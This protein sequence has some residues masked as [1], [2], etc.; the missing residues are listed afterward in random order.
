M[1][2][3]ME[4][5]DQAPT[6]SEELPRFKDLCIL[7]PLQK[8][9]TTLIRDESLDVVQLPPLRPEEPVQLLRAA[10]S[11]MTTYAHL[12]NYRFVLE[13]DGVARTGK[14]YQEAPLPC[15]YTG[16]NAVVSVPA[17]MKSLDAACNTKHE[18]VILDEYGDLSPLIKEG[19]KEGSGFRIVLERYDAAAI[20]D[21]ILRLRQLLDGNA[22]VVTSLK[23]EEEIEKEEV[24]KNDKQSVPSFL[25]EDKPLGLEA[26]NLKDFFYLTCGEV[27]PGKVIIPDKTVNSTKQSK[28]AKK[29]N[30]KSKA[31]AKSELDNGTD[32][33]KLDDLAEESF[34]REND[35]S[36]LNELEE[37][38]RIKCSIRYSGFHPPPSQRRLMGDLAYLEVSMPDG[39]VTHVTVIPTGFYVSRTS[40][41]LSKFD[42]SPAPNP[43]FSHELLDCL[44]Q[45][46]DSFRLAWKNALV[47]SKDR[48]VL[49]SSFSQTE[50]HL[51]S[52]HRVAVRGDFGGFQDPSTATSTQ[53]LDQV[54]LRPSWLV[55]LPEPKDDEEGWTHNEFH[56]YNPSRADDDIA[57]TFGLDI[58]SGATRDWNE[59]IQSSREMPAS[60]TLERVEKARLIH[61]VMSE[62]GEAAL[63]GA[64]SIF[65]GQIAPMNPNEPAR[66][67]VYLHNNIFFSRAVDAG[68]ETFKLSKGDMAAKKSASRDAQ[69]MGSLHRLDMDGL[70]T[71]GTVVIDYIGTRFVCQSVVPGILMGEKS[72]KLL[73][74][75]VEATSPLA[76]DK[77]T[78]DILEKYLGKAFMVATRKVPT[79]PFTDERIA[80]IEAIKK[81]NPIPGEPNVTARK[82]VESD[83]PTTTICAPVEAKGI[84]GSDMRTYVLDMPRIT[85]RD[86]NWVP[87]SKGGTGKWEDVIASNGKGRNFVPP[88]LEDEEFIMAVLRSELVTQLTRKKMGE[89]TVKKEEE[90][91]KDNIKVEASGNGSVTE[92]TTEQKCEVNH[93]KI[94]DEKSGEAGES[95]DLNIVDKNCNDGR[96]DPKIVDGLT[97]IEEK[98]LESLRLNVNVFL[99]NMRSLVGVDDEAAK[100]LELDMHQVR[101]ASIYLW[102]IVLP[103]LTVNMRD[104][105]GS[106]LPSDGRT[107]TDMLHQKGINCRYLGQLAMLAT[108][109]E[110][111]DKHALID[112]NTGKVTRLPRRT[113][114]L[115]WLE[116]LETE[117]IARAAKHILDSYLAE[118]GGVGASQP[119]QIIASFLSALVSETEET[120]AETETRVCKQ[121]SAST[122]TVPDDD[123]FTGLTMVDTGGG[124]DAVPVPIRSRKE[125]WEDIETEVGRR[126]R[127][128][129][130]L[131][132][133]GGHSTRALQVPLLR[134]VS[135][136]TGVRLAARNYAVGTKCLC[137]GSSS[138]GGRM[139]ASFPISPVDIIDV[140]PLMKHCAAQPGE[141]FVACSAG[142][143]Y[144]L[145][146]LYIMLPEAKHLLE[147][148][149][150]H[151]SRRNLPAALELAQE[152]A[153]LFQRVTDTHLHINVA[154]CLD[155]SAAVLFEAK[156]FG[157]A[158]SN[159]SRSLGVSVQ[160]GG[161]DC[162]DAMTGH[163]TLSHFLIAD[164]QV[165][166]GAKHLKAAIYLMELFSGPRYVELPNAYHRLGTMFVNEGSNGV[167]ALRCYQEASSRPSSDRL[168]EGMIMKSTAYLLAQLGQYKPAVETEARAYKL[169]S[170]VVGGDHELTKSCAVSLEK[171]SKLNAERGARAIADKQMIDDEALALA[172]ADQMVADEE[173]EAQ[174]NKKNTTKRGKKK[175]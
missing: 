141:G 152:A 38:T 102:D 97:E 46:S 116:L 43:C 50:G 77:G 104:G 85:P 150:M 120:A 23:P 16:I 121:A 40:T 112:F 169:Y 60:S 126:F 25:K 19:L 94:S 139:S 8:K 81:A 89:L 93:V 35:I 3:E 28:S 113:M 109:E 37:K 55:P 161:F 88:S 67:H 118:N 119:A 79:K 149:H 4:P 6:L 14:K 168:V 171:Y 91:P 133:Q 98:Y 56:A 58:R 7:P 12:T 21:H 87:K 95:S 20:K 75:A 39:G 117:M 68:V 80:E 166:A 92:E 71:L 22:P 155:L 45:A 160:I 146:T 142:P 122:H 82:E 164:G 51:S 111:K 137:S 74:G 86:A 13:V 127:Y 62:F 27:A 114:P 154:R 24:E 106:Q 76:W 32:D 173:T 29:R 129:I 48:S 63:I 162:A 158:A 96:E 69:C 138:E 41:I 128:K 125:V 2:S 103:T 11:E 15:P 84:Q 100:Q 42:P 17:S 26:T 101:E 18:Q 1:S 130:T 64:K 49:T 163:S 132:N 174:K 54:I 165:E 34:T 31:K 5:D 9:G 78:H 159:A 151:F 145:P 72:H 33:F 108:V 167:S 47:A 124:G 134:R 107:L 99:P 57:N 115:C 73:Y 147:G 140:V 136:R 135:Q 70:Y 175:K 59:E 53:G 44:I 123:D 157:L 30:A 66:S 65:H 170:L 143:N 144:T 131:F 10:L 172:M 105:D 153:N 36:K 83:A 148:A 61:K 110:D 90:K 52:L 156:E